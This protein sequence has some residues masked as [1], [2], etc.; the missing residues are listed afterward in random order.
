MTES[1]R[2]RDL[3]IYFKSRRGHPTAVYVYV[4][5]YVYVDAYVDVYVDVYV[6]ARPGNIDFE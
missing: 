4:Y 5:V 6:Y 2:M 3:H 1:S